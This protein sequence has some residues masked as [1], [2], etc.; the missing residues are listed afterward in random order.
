MKRRAVEEHDDVVR[1]VEDT[2]HKGYRVA[3]ANDRWQ[4]IWLDNC[5]SWS[6]SAMYTRDEDEVVLRF[7]N[8][9]GKDEKLSRSE[10]FSISNSNCDSTT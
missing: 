5:S 9:R 6:V 2:T 4:T 8:R 10:K 3:V 1:L 7:K